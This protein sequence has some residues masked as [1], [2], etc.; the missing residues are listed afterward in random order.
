[1]KFRNQIIFL[2]LLII[3]F[4][5]CQDVQNNETNRDND[6]EII[7]SKENEDIKTKP[8]EK[9]KKLGYSIEVDDENI[10]SIEIE[11]IDFEE[12]V[13]LTDPEMD[14]ILFCA[15]LSQQALKTKFKE[16]VN[17]I[18][19]KMGEPNPKKV[20]DKLGSEFMENCVNYVE[21]ET[22]NI[23]ITNLTYHNNFKWEKEFDNYTKIDF[24]KYNSTEDLKYTV[25]QQVL[26]K[27]LRQSNEEFEKRRRQ[28]KNIREPEKPKEV[29]V[30]KNKNIDKHFNNKE[31]I[32]KENIWKEIKFFTGFVLL[33]ITF[34]GIIYFLKNISSGKKEKIKKEKNKKEKIN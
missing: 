25:E 8:E 22:V 33:L 21:Q 16:D 26:L 23:Y 20:Y 28:R 30:N 15:Y 3:C 5:I 18:A 34:V 2:I 19:D 17:Q 9:S 6:I 4:V 27:F 32:I 31:S 12:P 10:K 24:N 13:E 1:M 11:S 14:M 7:D 29:K